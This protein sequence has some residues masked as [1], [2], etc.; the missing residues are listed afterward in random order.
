MEDTDL[1]W[2][3]SSYSGN[4][5]GNCVEVASTAATVHVRDTKSRE[6][7]M[8]TVTGAAWQAFLADIKANLGHEKRALSVTG[9]CP[10]AVPTRCQRRPGWR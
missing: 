5:G 8:L 6:R 10:F 3:K 2:R 9:E 4:G 1:N 7:G